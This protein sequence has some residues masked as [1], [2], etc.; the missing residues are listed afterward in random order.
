MDVFNTSF[1]YYYRYFGNHER[2]QANSS[3]VD[4]CF[5]IMLPVLLSYSTTRSIFLPKQNNRREQKEKKNLPSLAGINYTVEH[6][7]RY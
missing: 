1:Y 5:L 6:R 3:V 7:I 4:E 2:I